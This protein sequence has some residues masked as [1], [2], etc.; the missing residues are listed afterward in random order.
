MNKKNKHFFSK[1]KFFLFRNLEDVEK[2]FEN[3]KCFAECVNFENIDLINIIDDK[4]TCKSQFA[5]AT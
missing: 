3:K 1:K 5:N 4:R 2:S